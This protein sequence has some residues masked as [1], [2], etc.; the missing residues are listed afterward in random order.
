MKISL[1]EHK[2][3]PKPLGVYCWCLLVY[4]QKVVHMLC[5]HNLTHFI[6][7]I[8]EVEQAYPEQKYVGNPKILLPTPSVSYFFRYNAF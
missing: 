7:I 1:L 5:I 2:A 8:S 4:V 6:Y 3:L